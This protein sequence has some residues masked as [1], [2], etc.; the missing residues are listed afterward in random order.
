MNFTSLLP[1]ASFAVLLLIFGCLVYIIVRDRRLEQMQRVQQ[2]L[3]EQRAAAAAAQSVNSAP[4]QTSA[5]RDDYAPLRPRPATPGSLAQPVAARP[6]RK[7]EL[8][9]N[10]VS[11]GEFKPDVLPAPNP[12]LVDYAGFAG[13]RPSEAAAGGGSINVTGRAILR[14]TPPPEKQIALDP[15]CGRLHTKPMTTRHFIVGE[16]GGLANVFVYVKSGAVSL[17]PPVAQNV[18]LDQVGCEFQP[19][20]LGVQVNQTLLVRNSDPLM[21]N[22]H[23]TPMQNRE[24][25]VAQRARG[26]TTPFVFQRPEVLVRF[27][28]DVHPWM[29]AYAGVVD[30]P[31]FAVT[32]KNGKFTLPSG[33]S[34]GRYTLAAVHPKA[35]EL[36]QDLTINASGVEPVTFVFE[37]TETLATR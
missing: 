32:D 13:T 28:C 20:V 12:S 11:P 16:T 27:K 10:V 21:H 31:W 36:I 6:P 29:F 9:Q 34:S 35:G 22:V 15:T 8:A 25:T 17:G 3:D 18:L 1:K 14:G 23:I 2:Q 26:M 37:A 19:Y 5:G 30:H 4:A 7:A 33:L 24:R